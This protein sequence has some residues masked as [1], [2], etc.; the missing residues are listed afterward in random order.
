VYF[1][2]AVQG[3]FEYDPTAVWAR[4][5]RGLTVRTASGHHED[6]IRGGVHEL[7]DIVSLSLN[8][9]GQIGSD[10][11]SKDPSFGAQ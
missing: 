2:A 5:A 9:T 11:A 7:G 3:A 6:L 8:G 4:L 10:R 1:K